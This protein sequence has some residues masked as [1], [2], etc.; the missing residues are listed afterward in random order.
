M[1]RRNFLGSLLAAPAV[2]M[3]AGCGDSDSDSDSDAAASPSGETSFPVTVQTAY[4]EV[5]I[6]KQPERVVVLSLDYLEALVGLGLKPVAAPT[7]YPFGSW[8]TG[9]IDVKDTSVFSFPNPGREPPIE[10]IASMRPDLIVGGVYTVTEDTVGLLSNIA[11]TVSHDDIAGSSRAGAWESLTRQLGAA[12]GR[13]AEA[14]ALIAKAFASIDDVKKANPNIEGKKVI[15]AGISPNGIAAT[16]GDR[17]SGMRLLKAL[18][19]DQVD[20]GVSA[21]EYAGGRA[22]LSLEQLNVFD[23]ADF[24]ILGAFTNELRDAIKVNPLYTSLEVVKSGRVYEIDLEGTYAFNTPTA[25]N[26]PPILEG[27]KPALAKVV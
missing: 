8:L 27:M 10:L 2:L 17:H 16:I 3:V 14:D 23:K 5:T 15:F 21:S 1:R 19:F 18:G 26:I 7:G 24:V 12:T 22:S 9:K 25:L 11:P 6:P 20:L 13:N 4:G